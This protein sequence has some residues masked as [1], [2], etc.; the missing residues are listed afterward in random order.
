MDM[1]QS[2]LLSS[3]FDNGWFVNGGY[4]DDDANIETLQLQ[5]LLKLSTDFAT[6]G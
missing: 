5:H 4:D 3:A 2:I 1:P 6:L